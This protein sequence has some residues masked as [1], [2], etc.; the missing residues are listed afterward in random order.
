MDE[1]TSLI[2]SFSTTF[3]AIMGFIIGNP[4]T[5]AMFGV[6]LIMGLVG[7]VIAFFRGR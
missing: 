4:Y 1:I 7:S 2:T 5:K 6:V 3:S